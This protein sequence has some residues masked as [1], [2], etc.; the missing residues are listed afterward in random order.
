MIKP[1]L[2][3][4]AVAR[5]GGIVHSRGRRFR[6]EGTPDGAV[7]KMGSEGLVHVA[8]DLSTNISCRIKCFWEPTELRLKRSEIL[9]KQKLADLG[10]PFAD[11]LGGAPYEIIANVGPHTPYA[12]VMK[13]VHGFSWKDLKESGIQRSKKTK[14]YPPENW[15]GIGIR[16][17]WAYGLATAVRNM[18]RRNFVHADLSDGNVMVTPSGVGAGDMALVDFDAFVHPFYQFLDST[19][20]GSEGYAAPE[21]WNST[22]VGIGSDRVGM[23]ILIQEFLVAGE[24]SISR[25]EGFGWSYNQTNEICSKTGEGHPFFVKQYPDLA[26]LLIRTL[27][28]K[29]PSDRPEPDAWRPILRK[30]VAGSIRKRLINVS[31]E[32]HTV[33][34]SNTRVPFPDTQMTL[35]LL[36]SPYRIHAT[37]ERNKDGSVDAVLHSGAVLHI[38]YAKEGIWKEYRSGRA[39]IE[40]GTKLFDPQGKIG[41]RI[42]AQ[43]AADQRK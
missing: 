37:L 21:I 28:A 23:A 33:V 27:R 18:E 26:D 24:P 10:K 36:N 40:P 8:T 17:T 13:D 41:A 1:E 11:A 6:I 32:A 34:K 42:D 7:F 29:N 19:C 15:A 31:V 35:D 30:I 25:D 14:R 5:Q 22:S 38:Q 16:A 2:L 43:E 3:T 20:K 4:E 12:I 39:A 9:V